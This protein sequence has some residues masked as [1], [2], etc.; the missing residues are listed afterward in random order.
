[1]IVYE[2]A[3]IGSL[4]FVRIKFLLG[5]LIKSW[6]MRTSFETFESS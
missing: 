1:M 4:M 5:L 2:K 3:R 6:E